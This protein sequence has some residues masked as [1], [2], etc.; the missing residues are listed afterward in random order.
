MQQV[1]DCIDAGTE[2][3]PC[4]LAEIDECILCSQL[5][6]K[7]FCDCRNWKGVCIYQEYVGN[8]NRMKVSRK[9]YLCSIVKKEIV[10]T[11]TLIITV[12][13]TKTMARE[14]NQPGAFIFMRDIEDPFYFDTPMSIMRANERE[15]TIE[16]AI[17]IRGVKTKALEDL[18][19]DVII[20]GPYWNGLLGLKYL[21]TLK[22]SKAL[23]ITRGIGQA[24][25]ISVA[26]KLVLAGNQVEVVLD[27]G[28]AGVNFTIDYFKEIGCDIRLGKVLDEE[29]LTVPK[30]M[31]NYIKESVVERGIR[32]VYSGGSEKL[33]KGIKDLL[34]QLTEEVYFV[35]SNDARF[36]CGEGVCGSCHTR[37][38]DGT[39]I[40]TCKTQM[41]PL[42]I[43]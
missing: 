9:S 19:E 1:L 18:G 8:K 24:P 33:H 27:K 22:N 5:Q 43:L 39:R 34:S 15:G 11:N 32:L 2:Y 21:K 41:N 20:R 7:T 14:L 13:V 35:C 25:A 6:G 37:M 40:K 12:L 42:D 30:E 17:Q 10:N 36:C 23:L 4:Y 28:R 31:L 38:S 29:K 3:C 26:R 16:I